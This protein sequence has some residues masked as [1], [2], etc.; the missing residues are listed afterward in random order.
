MKR[1]HFPLQRILALRRAQSNVE[2]AKLNALQAEL[3]QVDAKAG[4]ITLELL[5]AESDLRSLSTISSVDL[6]NLGN[7]RDFAQV[8][9]TRLA[10]ARKEIERRRA[11]QMQ[12]VA[13]KR[14]DVKLLEKLRERKLLEWSAE[15]ERELTNQTEEFFLARWQKLQ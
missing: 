3:R 1:F 6:A 15:I 2:E 9:R 5:Q 13:Q 14:R 7:Y 4:A 12:V 11:L 10:A 8:Q